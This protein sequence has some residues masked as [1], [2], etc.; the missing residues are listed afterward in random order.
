VLEVGEK[1]EEVAGWD[2]QW[3]HRDGRPPGLPDGFEAAIS[4]LTPPAG[5][6]F[7]Y[8]LGESRAVTTLKAA[9]A[10]I[11]LGSERSYVKGYWN[12]D[13]PR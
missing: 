5:N 13:R 6:G 12:R 3:L 1:A 8:V 9:L 2:A 4:A 7:A 10:T 11:G